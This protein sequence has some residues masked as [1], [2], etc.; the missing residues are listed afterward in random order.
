M[1]AIAVTNEGKNV[2]TSTPYTNHGYNKFDLSHTVLDTM[3][4]GELLPIPLIHTIPGDS[5]DITIPHV[6]ESDTL[7]S[8]LFSGLSLKKDIFHI[9]Y[10]ILMP[11]QWESFL[12]VPDVNVDIPSACKPLLNV[13]FLIDKLNRDFNISGTPSTTNSSNFHTLAQRLALLNWFGPHGIFPHMGYNLDE[14]NL[15]LLYKNAET[16][17]NTAMGNFPVSAYVLSMFGVGASAD[18]VLQK[19]DNSSTKCTA[20]CF[21]YFPKIYIDWCEKHDYSDTLAND[22][23]IGITIPSGFNYA[24]FSKLFINLKLTQGK[25][26][27]SLSDP[28][29]NANGSN[30]EYF[31]NILPFVAYKAITTHFYTNDSVDSVF[32]FQHYMN[33]MDVFADYF[34]PNHQIPTDSGPNLVPDTFS[35]FCLRWVLKGL[36]SQYKVLEFFFNIFDYDC[37]LKFGDYFTTSNVKPLAGLDS[38]SD[39][40][41]PVTSGRVNV[42]DVRHALSMQKFL[43]MVN[44]LGSRLIDYSKGIFGVVPSDAPKMFPEFVLRVGSTIDTDGVT[45]TGDVESLGD[46]V[47]I[48][49]SSE[50]NTHFNYRSDEFGILMLIY[51]IDANTAYSTGID[52]HLLHLDRYDLFNPY[53]ENLGDQ[54]IKTRE[55]INL[56]LT[57][58]STYDSTFGYQMR[59]AEYKHANNRF[60]SNFRDGYRSWVVGYGSQ[61][62]N[63]PYDIRSVSKT[64]NPDFVHTTEFDIDNI[65]KANTGLSPLHRSQF[66]IKFP[67]SISSSRKINYHSSIV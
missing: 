42:Y 38:D 39:I 13:V 67:I 45:S 66:K 50:S 29:Y 62:G 18:A 46:R 16:A 14:P 47:A 6:L 37:S 35:E 10:R 58:K 56:P 25:T 54:E 34:L 27:T 60:L 15:M 9:P 26:T 1:S 32:S 53:L 40:Q 55:L 5:H 49:K 48:A 52:K 51:H 22:S 24:T 63:S 64:L 7:G 43:N 41:I 11:H 44:R 57:E 20:Y 59:Y 31:I 36:P 12:T 23:E 65:F 4:Y 19:F 61:F 28:T 3:Q 2:F 8:P 17:L 33:N 21:R 30:K